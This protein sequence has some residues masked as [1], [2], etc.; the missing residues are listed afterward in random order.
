[1]EIK[2]ECY[3]CILLFTLRTARQVTEDEWLLK[4]V[5]N[6]TMEVLRDIGTVQ[7]PP[8]VA[9]DVFGRIVRTLGQKD[10]LKSERERMNTEA[11]KLLPEAEKL[12][13]TANDPLFA[14]MKFAALGNG[15]DTLFVEKHLLQTKTILEQFNSKKFHTNDYEEFKKDIS[16]ARRLLYILDNAGEIFFDKLLIRYL[17]KQYKKMEVTAVVR[18]DIVFD[19]ATYEDAKAAKIEEDAKVID[20]GFS[21]LGT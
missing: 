13:T 7:T 14:A 17:K 5:M 1:M 20:C 4:K 6:E 9:T 21:T 8:E 19:D 12:V 11:K 18:K 15:F 2:P 3:P 16:G 10:P